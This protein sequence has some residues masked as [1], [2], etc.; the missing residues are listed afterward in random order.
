MSPAPRAIKMI[1]DI[2]DKDLLPLDEVI[3]ELPTWIVRHIGDEMPVCMAAIVRGASNMWMPCS[4]PVPQSGDLCAE[5]VQMDR[6]R[7]AR[8]RPRPAAPPFAPPS[9]A[10]KRKR[11]PKLFEEEERR[12]CQ[13]EPCVRAREE[14]QDLGDPF[15]GHLPAAL[16]EEADAW[17]NIRRRRRPASAMWRNILYRDPAWR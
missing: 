14:R 16:I 4:V 6:V 11:G 13:D 2:G 9:L 5:H 12:L 10:R 17:M 1:Y 15:R 7:A 8:D 3:A